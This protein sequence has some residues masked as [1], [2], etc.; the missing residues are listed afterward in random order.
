MPFVRRPFF[1]PILIDKSRHVI[2]F[3]LQSALAIGEAKIS[4][5]T[6]SLRSPLF[7]PTQRISNFLPSNRGPNLV[8]SF[9]VPPTLV[10]GS[11]LESENEV[12]QFDFVGIPSSPSRYANSHQFLMTI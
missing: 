3:R 7:P 4:P 10:R 2:H 12:L 8:R 6:T 5:S 11:K 9:D 1:P